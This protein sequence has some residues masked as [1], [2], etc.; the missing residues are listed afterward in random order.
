MTAE[1]RP[2]PSPNQPDRPLDPL[3]PPAPLA[4]RPG[5]LGILGGTFDPIHLGHLAAA[6]EAREQL[7][8]EEVVFIPTGVP[9]QKTGRPVS[10]GAD[11]LAMLEL[12]IEGNRWFRS[13]AIELERPGPSYSV[14]TI[15]ALATAE[16]AAGRDPDLWFIL[17]T[18]AARG[19]A[20]WQR[21]DRLLAGCRLAVVP[22]PG[23]A[24][25][26]PGALEAIVPGSADRVVLLDAPRLDISGTAIRARVRVGRSIRYLVP[27]AVEAYILEHGL[28]RPPRQED[29]PS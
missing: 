18:E 4:T 6:E 15:E 9:W 3:D 2:D 11:R 5:R 13:S 26:D 10:A 29:R 20:T 24:P 12:A 28:Y 14:D 27:A 21:P 23:A 8:F 7:G 16:R 17:S 19:L 1:R 25:F 22:R